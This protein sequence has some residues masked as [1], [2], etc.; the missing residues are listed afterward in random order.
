MILKIKIMAKYFP[1]HKG[2]DDLV[3]HK[4]VHSHPPEE[5]QSSS[6]LENINIR[7][8]RIFII[9]VVF[10]WNMNKPR[11]SSLFLKQPE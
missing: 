3:A 4:Q 7:F 6:G 5:G 1:L 11:T 9:L 8:L 2:G 10:G